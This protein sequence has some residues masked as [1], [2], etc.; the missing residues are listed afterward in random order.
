MLEAK[1]MVNLALGVRE[2][3]ATERAGTWEDPPACNRYGSGCGCIAGC[4][5]LAVPVL[6]C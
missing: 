2:G 1:P 5:P 3:T 6:R 4:F